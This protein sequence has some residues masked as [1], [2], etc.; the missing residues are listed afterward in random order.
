MDLLTVTTVLALLPFLFGGLVV[1]RAVAVRFLDA[2][3]ALSE[4]ELLLHG[5]LFAI[6]INGVLGT[7]LAAV[8]LF[9]WPA[10][11]AALGIAL[12]VFRRDA[13]A[14]AKGLADAARAPAR[15]LFALDLP[16]LAAW[17]AFSAF[18]AGLFLLTP[19]PGANVDVWVFQ[20]PLAQSIVDNAGFV[21]PQIGHPF[22][23]SRPLFTNLLW[24]QALL[25]VDHASAASVVT[26]AIYVGFCL[27]LY[28]FARR[29]RPLALFLLVGAVMAN[30]S[31]WGGAIVPMIDVPRASFS[32]LALVFLWAYLRD[33]V[34]YYL[35]GAA[36]LAGA[37]AGTKYTELTTVALAAACM[38]PLL[39]ST[40][41]VRRFALA[42][43]IV[44]LVAGYWYV[45]NLFLLGNPVYPFLFG[46]PGLSDEWMASLMLDLTRTFDPALRG[47]YSQDL[48]SWQGWRDFLSVLSE[49]FLAR[50]YATP[51]LVV[52]VAAAVF[53]RNRIAV[54]VAL[55]GVLFV[56]WYVL[57]FTHIRWAQTAYLL[58]WSTGWLA[59][60]WW[61]ERLVDSRFAAGLAT[62]GPVTRV[63]ALWSRRSARAAALAAAVAAAG[64][65][66]LAGPDRLFRHVA[67]PNFGR[68]VTHILSPGGLERYLSE[69][70]PG[71][72]I[73]RHIT[74]ND[75]RP[76]LQP[77]DYNAHI[78]AAA[79]SGGRDGKWLLPWRSLPETVDRTE[80]F[81]EEQGV[82]YFIR[83]D[84]LKPVD[85]EIFERLGGP[86]HVTKAYAVLDRLMPRARPVF[87]DSFGWTLYEIDGRLPE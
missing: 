61:L 82:R 31:F 26:L 35:V 10:L 58:F 2:S 78:M 73:Y 36:L 20:L 19:I 51:L 21:H 44:L 87:A 25:F 45:R 57:M 81:I 52:A 84:N 38:L 8:G 23:G 41:E 77:L 50:P 62:L 9:A 65:Y 74:R 48:L 6:V 69:T 55:T 56:I 64:F 67:G 18:A 5:L 42:A 47:V 7:Y 34:P 43:G 49:W 76:V 27:S 75:L 46:H 4:R 22:Y 11:V 60:V 29:A 86:E 24:A 72:A 13:V 79:Y 37:A 68:L 33:R 54:L 16:A 71:Y 59:A 1:H 12:G 28:A 80:A 32:V 3:K 85:V 39:R 83:R 70:R 17:G 66:G 40:A 53:P 30:Y 14:V 15:W 63:R